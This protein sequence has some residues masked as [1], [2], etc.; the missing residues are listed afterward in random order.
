MYCTKC[1]KEID[2]ITAVCPDCGAANR[3]FD[4]SQQPQIVINNTNINANSNVNKNIAVGAANGAKNKWVAI[5]LCFFFGCFGLHKFYEGKIGI[6]VL[7]LFTMG[8]FGIGVFIDFIALLFK[9]NPY[10]V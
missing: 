2:N 8:I 6:G 1:G 9:S 7:Y 4:A 3:Y 10:Y 5:V